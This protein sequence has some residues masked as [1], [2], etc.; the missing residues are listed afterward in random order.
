MTRVSG[1]GVLETWRCSQCAHEV[2][3]HVQYLSLEPSAFGANEPVFVLMATWT[4]RPT[5]AKVAQLRQLVPMM[6]L[7][8]DAS[9]LRSSA[10]GTE[11]E[12]GRFKDGEMRADNLE[13]RLVELGLRL[14][15]K[16]LPL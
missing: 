3:V 4:A 5:E 1:R 9:L 14:V 8:T 7:V 11:F 12:L 2:T 15:R 13:S 10:S 16:P 6:S